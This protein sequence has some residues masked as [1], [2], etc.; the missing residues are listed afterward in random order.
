MQFQ[1]RH[2]F[3]VWS[4]GRRRVIYYR[5]C[6]DTFFSVLFSRPSLLLRFCHGPLFVSRESTVPKGSSLEAAQKGSYDKIL[7]RTYVGCT[8]AHDSILVDRRLPAMHY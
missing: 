3:L 1:I 5:S 8:A 6:H 7:A 4:L 2:T